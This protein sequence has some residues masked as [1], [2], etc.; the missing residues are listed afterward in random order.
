MTSIK[1]DRQTVSLLGGSEEWAAVRDEDS[2]EMR[3]HWGSGKWVPN[4][5]EDGQTLSLY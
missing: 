2:H 1:K 5:R 4:S 3:L